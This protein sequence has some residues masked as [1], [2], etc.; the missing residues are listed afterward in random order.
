MTRV[1]TCGRETS[2]VNCRATHNIGVTI[3]R[4]YGIG[5]R[6]KVVRIRSAQDIGAEQVD[7]PVMATLCDLCAAW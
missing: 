1:W 6:D 3:A 5:H 2:D 7:K 4:F